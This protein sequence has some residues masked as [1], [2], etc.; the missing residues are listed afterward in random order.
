MERTAEEDDFSADGVAARQNADRL[1]DDGLEDAR[2]DIFVACAI[3]DERLDIGFCEDATSRGD[4]IYHF[5]AARQ[6]VEAFRIGI[7]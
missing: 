4:G 2:G 1:I 6:F 3:V 7:E 5:I